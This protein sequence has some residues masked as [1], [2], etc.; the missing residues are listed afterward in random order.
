MSL[1]TLDKAIGKTIDLSVGDIIAKYGDKKA[2]GIAVQKKEIDPTKAAM[3]G[4]AIDRLV[5]NAAQ[6][7]STTVF[8]DTFGPPQAQAGIG[9]M[10]PQTPTPQMGQSQMPQR[11]GQ[12]LNQVPVPQRGFAEGGV[13]GFQEGGPSFSKSLQSLDSFF[14]G[15]NQQPLTEEELKEY[16]RLK[17]LGM[18]DAVKETA[19]SLGLS[20]EDVIR[21]AVSQQKRGLTAIKEGVIDPIT[22]Y[23][24]KLKPS[25]EIYSPGNVQEPGYVPPSGP[26]SVGMI[27]PFSATQTFAGDNFDAVPV[28]P[29]AI[30]APT[31]TTQPTAKPP[32]APPADAG[33]ASAATAQRPPSPEDIQKIQAKAEAE[34]LTTKEAFDKYYAEDQAILGVDPR[35]AARKA[36]YEKA[37]KRDFTDRL[38]ENALLF[39]AG[40]KIAKGVLPG[41]KT[42]EA[43]LADVMKLRGEK[44]KEALALEKEK[45]DIEGLEYQRK[46]ESLGR[47]RTRQEKKEDVQTSQ[48]FQER[49]KKME[50]SAADQR[51]AKSIKS[52]LEI[53]NLSLDKKGD[54]EKI[55]ERMAKDPEFAKGVQLYAQAMGKGDAFA[56]Y[57]AGRENKGA[58]IRGVLESKFGKLPN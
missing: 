14:G 19:T 17:N 6:P 52:Q 48:D 29:D 34:G 55:I 23:I 22:G 35:I 21:K 56:A 43:E 32:A 45:A 38:M 24:S 31:A 51:L 30:T 58:D 13:V 46:A 40:E 28:R 54:V 15:P 41:Q 44:R 10:A 3:A 47:F 2:I 18:L 50:L 12:G 49:L 37:A 4:M 20:L 16:Q 9:A 1:E 36:A 42:G 39:Q 57:L 5:A 53:A 11:P 8:E 33:I 25:R 7:S 27:D 26:P